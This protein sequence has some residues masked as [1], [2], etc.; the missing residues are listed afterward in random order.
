TGAAVSKNS[1]DLAR[2]ARERLARRGRWRR[3]LFVVAV[4]GFFVAPPA[5]HHVRATSLLMTFSDATAKPDVVEE[6]LTI[7][8]PASGSTP[9]RTVKAR[10]FSPP[11]GSPKDLPAVVLVH[12]V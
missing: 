2:A 3:W 5:A 4:L 10:M 7:D 9:A 8:V 12:G 11:G 6:L 1:A